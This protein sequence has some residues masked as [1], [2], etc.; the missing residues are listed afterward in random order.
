MMNLTALSAMIVGM[1]VSLTAQCAVLLNVA[2]SAVL[3]H[4]WKTIMSDHDRDTGLHGKGQMNETIFVPTDMLFTMDTM[5]FKGQEPF[6]LNGELCHPMIMS[7]ALYEK[8]K[9]EN[10][11]RLNARREK[12]KQDRTLYLV[13]VADSSGAILGWEFD[14]PMCQTENHRID[15]SK[16]TLSCKQ[17]GE[18]FDN[19]HPYI[20]QDE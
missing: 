12:L 8:M 20:A 16:P 9:I 15:K 10:T 11:E 19:P 5:G 17:C 6:V 4:N 18:I 2:L 14:C 7:D 1:S 13:Q 3:K